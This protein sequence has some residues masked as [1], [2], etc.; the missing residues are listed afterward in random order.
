[1]G[2]EHWSVCLISF[3]IY[4]LLLYSGVAPLVWTMSNIKHLFERKAIGGK[5]F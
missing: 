3:F 4:C 2:S 5:L 1:M